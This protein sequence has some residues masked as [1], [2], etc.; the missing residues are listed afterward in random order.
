MNM[1][2]FYRRLDLLLLILIS[3]M[4]SGCASAPPQS[5]WEIKPASDQ[6]EERILDVMNSPFKIRLW[7]NGQ[8]TSKA[9]QAASVELKRV[10][11]I[12]DQNDAQS[13]ISKVNRLA[14]KGSVK[15]SR[16]LFDLLTLGQ[17]MWTRSGGVFDVTF[18][19]IQEAT[20]KSGEDAGLGSGVLE[21]A[22]EVAHAVKSNV[23]SHNLTLDPS[24][25]EVRFNKP[26]MKLGIL[27]IAKGYAVQK[28]AE[29]L[30][31][32]K[33]PGAAVIGGGVLAASGKALSDAQLM[34]I[35]HPNQLGTCAYRVLPKS[36]ASL[37]ILGASAVGDRPGHI[38]DPK[39][40]LRK[41]RSG[42]VTVTGTDGAA[43]QAAATAAGAMDNKKTA[44]FLA[45]PGTPTLSGVYFESDYGILLQGTLEPFAKTAPMR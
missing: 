9:F 34:C 24:K 15:V 44:A 16:E 3:A 25:L 27:G 1:Q 19:R 32:F 42:G 28:A 13:E 31:A 23:G 6:V 14:A 26:G 36:T 41:A 5:P 33:Y 38:Y 8:N 30:L 18:L 21:S 35:E 20:E 39:N 10:A 17:N 37:F 43:V 7:K 29:K 45:K 2:L 22:S 4:L 11:K 12:A 40:G